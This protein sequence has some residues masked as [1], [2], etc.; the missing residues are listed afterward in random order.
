LTPTTTHEQVALP[1]ELNTRRDFVKFPLKGKL[2]SYVSTGE[3]I[4]FS[5][6]R[7]ILLNASGTNSEVDLVA[8][9][10][11][12]S[13]YFHD[14][15]T[16]FEKLHE[17]FSTSPAF[18]KK[19]ETLRHPPI[20]Y[21]GHTAAFFVNK[22]HLGGFSSKRLDP[23]LEMQMAVGV[24][25]MSWDD[26]DPNS[27][28]WPSFPEA[29]ANP[30]EATA[31]L[32]KV[33][34]FRRNVRL[35]VDDMMARQPME[36][37]IKK[38][39]FWYV[40]LM[41]IEHEHIHIETSSVILRQAEMDLV[42]KSAFW[43]PC[44]LG[45]FSTDPQ[46]P[47]AHSCPKNRLIPI[48]AGS[49]RIGRPWEG[50]LTYGWDNEFGEVSHVP[51]AAFAASEYMVSNKEYLSFVEADGYGTRKW[52]SD[53]GWSWVSAMEPTQPRFWR[54]KDGQYSLRLFAEE[55]SMPW[56]WPVECNFH[57]AAAFCSFLSER[58]GKRI[59]LP[60][61]NEWLLLRDSEPT[62]LQES[63]HGPAWQKAPGNTNLEHW[64]SSC[65]V[66]HFRS[67][68]GL[69]DVLGNVWQHTP[70]TIDV[71]PTFKTHPLYDDF[72]TPTIDGR[73]T[74]ILGGSWISLGACATRD[75]R[76][77]F[78]RHFY[79]HAGFRYVESDLDVD[80]SFL[81]FERDRE[82]CN[83]FRFHFDPPIGPLRSNASS[84]HEDLAQHCR[85]AIVKLD[86]P[87]ETAKALELGCGP[88]RA[89][90]ELLK[91][92]FG[93]VQGADLTAKFFQYTAERLLV[94]GG[95]LRWVNYLEGE[96][97]SHRELVPSDLGLGVEDTTR[98]DWHQMPDFAAIDNHKFCNF[99]LVL[100]AQ[101]GLL[102]KAK[103]PIGILSSVHKLL[104][105]GGLLVIG[106]QYEWG[107]G[108]SATTVA[109]G[110][111]AVL[112]KLL[113]PW[114][115]VAMEP[116]DV[117]F[118]KPVT[119]RK[120][121]CGLQHVTFWQR[122]SD[123]LDRAAPPLTAAE[124]TETPAI[125]E[126]ASAL[127]SSYEFYFSSKDNFPVACA[128]RTI[129]IVKH[130]NVPMGLAL[131]V[132]GGLG[133]T[134]MELSK[135]FDH[136]D[137]IDTSSTLVEEANR[138]VREG[139]LSWRVMDDATSG[140]TVERSIS[141]SDIGFGSVA[142]LEKDGAT[143]ATCHQDK[144]YDLVCA[145]DVIHVLSDPAT[146]LTGVKS[147]LAPGGVFI[148]SSPYTWEEKT[149]P[150]SQW[151]GAYK[152]GDNDALSSYEALKEMM[153]ADGFAEALPPQEVWSRI[154]ELSNRRK[155]QQQLT[156]LTVWKR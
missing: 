109:N 75:A 2:D 77:G 140:V 68:S 147:V 45:R 5:A 29:E 150:K 71:L 124:T 36:W 148:L 138:F 72:T 132:G 16:V 15:F 39:S 53:E 74:R 12:I 112:A 155:S 18:F 50:T 149:T 7:T 116:V 65:P 118:A 73:H 101:P 121:D 99:D 87:L 55:V 100:C 26:L 114:F 88:G 28:V 44:E 144:Q 54:V 6:S 37:P 102:S 92:G 40:I 49:V 83:A 152:Y 129:E 61:E 82:L 38:D 33:F 111:T 135:S 136:V 62:D 106:T 32:Q 3:T 153:I 10:R 30:E 90:L 34:D 91:C 115:E 35:Y 70:T 145:F 79:Q 76:F 94:P 56:D 125:S 48:D 98:L 67:P 85:D 139:T 25:E 14:T 107:A 119:A 105:P 60:S 141:A 120:F 123:R 134:A 142:F 93:S 11:E 31:F 57:E 58:T 96:M 21:V 47:A 156:Q 97:V 84:F 113:Q 19:H 52:W 66:D 103:N 151:I 143:L 51:V 89:V 146:F 128:E 81:P 137:C 122:R 41:G 127:A 59:R 95:R 117:E 46:S 64:A 22:L 8:K 1:K 126:S 42:Q 86:R 110:G 20:F 133:R 23:V 24:D 104:K 17:I 108:S 27:Y 131:D 80:L 154:D 130:L 78:R 63:A 43:Q 4:D 13:E 9:K 69:C